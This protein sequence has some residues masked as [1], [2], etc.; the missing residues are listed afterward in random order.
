MNTT[1]THRLPIHDVAVYD[2]GDSGEEF[3]L[4]I[5]PVC[6]SWRDSSETHFKTILDI[7][8]LK[9]EFTIF[10]LKTNE[11]HHMISIGNL[12]DHS[13]LW[14]DERLNDKPFK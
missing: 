3:G 7:K 1:K 14:Q 5:G 6:F 2:I 10:C 8:V 9:S 12:Q 4:E 13:N 11:F